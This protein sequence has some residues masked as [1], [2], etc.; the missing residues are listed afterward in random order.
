MSGLMA[1]VDYV[2]HLAEARIQ[3]AILN[4]NE[5][6]YQYQRYL[7]DARTAREAGVKR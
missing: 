1:G 7:Y 3:P 6:E 5:A 4:P 2:F